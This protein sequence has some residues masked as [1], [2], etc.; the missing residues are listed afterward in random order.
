MLLLG[1]DWKL[2]I[3]TNILYVYTINSLGGFFVKKI[4]ECC[5]SR[6][7]QNLFIEKSGPPIF[8]INLC[9]WRLRCSLV[10]ELLEVCLYGRIYSTMFRKI[11]YNNILVKHKNESSEDYI[12]IIPDI[13]CGI[14]DTMPWDLIHTLHSALVMHGNLVIHIASQTKPYKF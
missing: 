10:P 5:F 3:N 13:W 14:A 11:F 9:Y 12:N 8:Q 7:P 6:W 4:T 1:S 2:N